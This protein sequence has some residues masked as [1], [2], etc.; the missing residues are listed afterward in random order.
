MG[1]LIHKWDGCKCIRC[2][3]I[4]KVRDS[5]LHDFQD[6]CTCVKCG[7]VRS[8]GHHYRCGVCTICGKSNP[9]E[10]HTDIDYRMAGDK[11]E[12]YCA[13][14]GQVMNTYTYNELFDRTIEEIKNADEAGCCSPGAESLLEW[15]KANRPKKGE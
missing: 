9:R 10:G 5:S 11:I 13:N 14:C 3:K 12:Y 7:E 8:Y 2:G 6:G 4:R 15:L 1:C